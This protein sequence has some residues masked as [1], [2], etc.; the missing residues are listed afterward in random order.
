ME[1]TTKDLWNA[2]LYDEKHSFVSNYGH[3]LI[4]LLNAKQGEKVL[5]LGCGTGDLTN[6]LAG[7]NLDVV[8]IDH[9]ENMI[10]QAQSKYPD[11]PFYIADATRLS[12]QNEF[13]C[14]FSNATLHWIKTPEAVLQG[15]Y[16]AL[17]PGG[18]MVVEFGGAGN[19][20][21]ITDELIKQIKEASITF[22]DEHFPW[23]F[24]TIGQY[25]SLLESI[26]FHVSYALH[27]SRPTKLSG[28]NGLRNWLE[29]F[30]PSLF[31]HVPSHIKNDIFNKTIDNLHSQLYVNNSWYADYKRI[32]IV[33][34]K[35]G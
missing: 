7:L 12:Y 9:S 24:P 18:R 15:I 8:G 1:K 25:S 26:G 21:I 31:E 13:D 2:N 10:Q 11:I 3:E 23:Y 4:E 6:V 29:M 22:T 19:V 14:V 5:D 30:S 33:A 32:R 34:I 16:Q 20:Q 17:K 28:E 35:K 27:F